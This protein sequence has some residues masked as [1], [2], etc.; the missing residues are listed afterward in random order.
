MHI[1]HRIRILQISNLNI[2]GGQRLLMTLLAN[3]DRSVFDV[4]VC[5]V[6]PRGPLAN[7][8]EKLGSSLYC[9]NW[10]QKP[11]DYG[12][13]MDLITLIKKGCYDIVHVHDYCMSSVYGGIASILA[14]V[15]VLV[16]T[17]HS[18]KQ[19]EN[20]RR[21]LFDIFFAMR[22]KRIF[23][24]S[25][26][27]RHHAISRYKV[28]PD[29]VVVVYSGVDPERVNSNLTMSQARQ[30]LSIPVNTTIIGFIGRLQLD[31]GMTL[32]I[33]A[34]R[35]VVR[36]YPSAHLVIVGDG[37]R[38]SNLVAAT[39]DISS[40]VHFLGFQ[41]DIGS[42]LQSMD[43]LVVPSLREGLGLVVI[44]GMMAG[45][46]VIA[47]RVGGIPELIED[48]INGILSGANPM[49]L[50]AAIRFL[51]SNPTK[52]GDLV[53]HAK[54]RALTYFTGEKFARSMETHYSQL[55]SF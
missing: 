32:L 5:S 51:L 47:T 36:D 27:V 24:I 21:R 35:L 45:I 53:N 43:M 19:P 4:D 50:A 15:P 30:M 12:V 25:E 52:L 11:H 22:I 8:V 28:P 3:I 2:G 31:K 37:E 44:E 18:T 16:M 7:E 14:R 6:Q 9:L 23:A 39:K 17:E 42:I 20:M 34:F 41:L 10:L 48:G 33:E 49:E 29:K 1:H 40:N 26:A 46:P 54:E 38:K 13:I 55:V